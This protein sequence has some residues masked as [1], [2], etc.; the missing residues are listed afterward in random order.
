MDH[1]GAVATGSKV[2]LNVKHWS[3]GYKAFMLW[4]SGTV[5]PLTSVLLLTC[6]AWCTGVTGG[7]AG[8]MGAGL[9]ARGTTVCDQTRWAGVISAAI[10]RTWF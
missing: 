10:L 5:L 4:S 6:E 1:S 9:G 3:E 8:Y 2:M 7:A